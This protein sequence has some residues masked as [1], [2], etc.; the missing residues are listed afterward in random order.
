MWK[1]RRQTIET[2]TELPRKRDAEQAV[3]AL[4]S[5][6][7]VGNRVPQTVEE[8]I[9]HYRDHELGRKSFAICM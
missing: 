5:N 7:D 6:I 2:A 9:N 4:R 8:L 3:V 1:Y